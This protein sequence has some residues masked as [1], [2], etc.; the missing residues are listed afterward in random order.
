MK[1]VFFAA[2]FF[3]IAFS[4]LA[5]DL[6]N[7]RMTRLPGM[8]LPGMV[9]REDNGIPHVFALTVHD[10]IFLNG[11]LH[12]QD[13]L[14][15]MDTTRRIASGTLAELLGTPALGNDIQLRTFGLRRAADASLPLYSAEARAAL[16]AYA[17]GVNAYIAA[18]PSLPAEYG[19]LEIT[20]IPA[21]TPVDSVA[22]G[23]LIAFGLSFDLDIDATVALISYQTAGKIVGFDGAVEQPVLHLVPH[24]GP[25]IRFGAVRRV[26]ESEV[27]PWIGYRVWLSNR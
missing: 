10:A 25:H 4:A 20:Q 5:Q 14:F 16:D 2:A 3:L 19:L 9:T 27:G 23:K 8:Q 11:W 17:A 21:W 13:R 18:H 1:R 26:H 22:V 6:P 12:A 24:V 7:G 15:Q